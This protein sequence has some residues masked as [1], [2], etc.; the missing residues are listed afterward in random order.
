LV[1]H[2]TVYHFLHQ[3]L[4]HRLIRRIMRDVDSFAGVFGEIFVD[5]LQES[6]WRMKRGM[7][8]HIADMGIERLLGRRFLNEIQGPFRDLIGSRS[9]FREGQGIITFG[10]GFIP[11]IITFRPGHCLFCS[12][13][14]LRQVDLL[15]AIRI[16]M[17]FI[18]GGHKIWDSN[19]LL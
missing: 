10:Q 1:Q 18:V 6:L 4:T 8:L 11:S 16:V 2:Y 7:R 12:T 19:F 17:E 3:W 5:L 15:F 13:H 14:P 9:L